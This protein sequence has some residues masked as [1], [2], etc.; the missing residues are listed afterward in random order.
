VSVAGTETKTKVSTF[1]NS[2]TLQSGKILPILPIVLPSGG[3]RH[4]DM[5]DN[6]PETHL[7]PDP[8]GP[9][10]NVDHPE[11][12]DT[13][14]LGGW[15]WIVLFGSVMTMSVLANVLMTFCVI[16]NRKKHSVVYFLHI[17]MFCIN[18]VPM[19]QNCSSSSPPPNSLSPTSLFSLVQ[20]F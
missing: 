19:S 14:G 8:D 18:L 7:P 6:Q 12:E 10:G 20:Y 15:V 17:L 2:G 16:F 4:Q 5:A 11:V 1:L 13:A 9:G 3:V